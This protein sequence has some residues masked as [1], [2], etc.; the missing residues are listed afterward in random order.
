MKVGKIR[1]RLAAIIESFLGEGAFVD[2]AKLYTNKGGNVYNDEFSWQGYV[3]DANG[4]TLC[5]SSY[6]TMTD[7]VKYGKISWV[8]KPTHTHGEITL[9]N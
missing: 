5:V 4:N 9:I 7:I 6:D 1:Q 8:G 3:K 2:P